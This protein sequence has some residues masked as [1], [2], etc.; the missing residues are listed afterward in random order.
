MEK[1]LISGCFLGENVRY[2]GITKK[3]PHVIINHWLAQ[4]RLIT[5]CPEV[6]GGLSTPRPPAEYVATLNKLITST[7]LDVSDAFYQ[8]ANNALRLC[9]Q[10]QIQFALLKES[11]P[12]CGSN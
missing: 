9:Q 5:I 6:S 1:I 8:G 12:S 4:N 11:S 3:A 2:N 10:H 7:K